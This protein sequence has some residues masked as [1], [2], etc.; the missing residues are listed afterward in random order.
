MLLKAASP[1]SELR[2]VES[3]CIVPPFSRED[4]KFLVREHCLCR[5]KWIDASPSSQPTRKDF[6][7]HLAI[8]E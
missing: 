2:E 8:S 6:R 3:S 1:T 5:E 7:T 4:S